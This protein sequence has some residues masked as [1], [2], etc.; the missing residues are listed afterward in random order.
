LNYGHAD[1]RAEGKKETDMAT[2]KDGTG[3]YDVERRVRYAERPGFRITELQ[4]SPTQEI[5][6]HSHS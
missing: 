3:L 5:P 2:L 6:S 1:Q 4:I